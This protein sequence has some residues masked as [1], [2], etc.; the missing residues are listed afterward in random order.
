MHFDR[1]A[2]D[3]ASKCIQSIL[4]RLLGYGRIWAPKQDVEHGPL[5]RSDFHQLAIEA[6]EPRF[7]F[8][9]NGPKMDC[10]DRLAVIATRDGLQS[11]V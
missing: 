5:S 10:R 3:F 8:E 9:F 1:I 7:R 11:S 4:Y 2:F 6:G